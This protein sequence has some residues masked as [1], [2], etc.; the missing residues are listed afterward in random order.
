MCF[1][2]IHCLHLGLKYSK[3]VS[4]YSQI[5]MHESIDVLLLVTFWN[6]PLLFIRWNML[7]M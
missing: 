6:I 7:L 4:P 5:S 3:D 1:L 2:N